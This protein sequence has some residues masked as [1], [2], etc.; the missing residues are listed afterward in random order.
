MK[1]PRLL[2][3]GD[4]M[5]GRLVDEALNRVPPEYPWGDTIEII[6]AADWRC[7]NLEC[8]ISDR[9]SPWEPEI[10]AFHFRSAYRNLAVLETASID[11]VTLANNHS[12]DFG[13]TALAQMIGGLDSRR[14]GHAGAGSDLDAA[15]RPAISEIQ[16]CRVG[17]L[18]F[19]DNEPQ[20]EATADTPGIL[21][22]PIDL[23]DPRSTRLLELVKASKASVDLLIV[24]AHWGPNWG[25]RPPPEH[26]GF[27]HALVE[28]G[29]DIVFGHSG[30]VFRGIEIYRRRPILYCAGNFIDDYA[31]DESE[32]NDESF[33]FIA[34]MEQRDR[35]GRLSLYP[36]VIAQFQARLARGA[37]AERIAMKMRRLCSQFNSESIWNPD[38]HV[39]EIPIA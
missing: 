18:A 6:R 29:A 15:S 2:L 5:L 30:H 25:Y 37:S 39:L 33:I 12:L 9:G 32:R 26:P 24:S 19:T 4:V 11:A 38:R 35:V 7:C 31:V 14:I 21:Y 34:E 16:G 8:V 36:T 20:W 22:A 13:F 10:K 23:E 17:L 1:T 27:A 3:A 28:H